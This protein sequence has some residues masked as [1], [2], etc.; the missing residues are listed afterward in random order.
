MERLDL[1][2]GFTLQDD[3]EVKCILVE[4]DARDLAYIRKSDIPR[5][6]EYL[7]AHLPTEEFFESVDK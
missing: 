4:D 3:P 7:R 6:I 2:D 1:G 5:V